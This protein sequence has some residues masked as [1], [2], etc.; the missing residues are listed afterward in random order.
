MSTATRNEQ[1][2]RQHADGDG[3]QDDGANVRAGIDV[4]LKGTLGVG[5][6]PAH[7]RRYTKK[8]RG[9]GLYGGGIATRG[10]PDRSLDAQAA[11]ARSGRALNWWEVTR[12][13]DDAFKFE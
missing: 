11:R 12:A 7:V 13:K 2:E 9:P 6:D 10:A 1:H 4:K 5:V 3:V 8:W